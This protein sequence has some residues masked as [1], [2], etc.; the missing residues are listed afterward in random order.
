MCSCLLRLIQYLLGF[1]WTNFACNYDN[2]LL[3]LVYLR[4]NE[5]LPFDYYI[6]AFPLH[7]SYDKYYVKAI[8]LRRREALR[9]WKQNKGQSATFENLIRAFEGAGCQAYADS[10]RKIC[11]ETSKVFFCSGCYL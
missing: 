3:I 5:Y 4:P 9:K 6:K 7:S 8:P 1:S 11:K 2:Q 10:V